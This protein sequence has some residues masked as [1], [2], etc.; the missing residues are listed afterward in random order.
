MMATM[1]MV[2]LIAMMVTMMA[3]T[4]SFISNKP[5]MPSCTQFSD[6]IRCSGSSISTLR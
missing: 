2:R 3:M 1:L 6:G 4:G 5:S